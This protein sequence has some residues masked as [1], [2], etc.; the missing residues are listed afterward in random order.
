MSLGG[1]REAGSGSLGLGSCLKD[2]C[3]FMTEK[4]SDLTLWAKLARTET[5]R[6][7]ERGLTGL[8]LLSKEEETYKDKREARVTALHSEL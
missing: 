4:V 6:G 1:G 7:E 5:R 8:D 2:G 3:Q